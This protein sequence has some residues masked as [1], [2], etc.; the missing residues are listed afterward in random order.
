MYA[1]Q[2]DRTLANAMDRDVQIVH[3]GDNLLATLPIIA[4]CDYVLVRNQHGQIC[5]IVTTADLAV[6]FGNVAKPFFTIGEIEH[7]LR[8]F[9]TPVFDCDPAVRK[10]TRKRTDRVGEM[11]FGD[12]VALLRSPQNWLRLGWPFID[13]GLF[14]ELLDRVRRIRNAVVHFRPTT[15]TASEN[16]QVDQLLLMLKNIGP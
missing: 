16:E 8:R 10:A 3:T 11:M 5:G 9:L 13:H 2:S 7:R 4:A 12:Y 14:I 1:S 6:Q 15:L